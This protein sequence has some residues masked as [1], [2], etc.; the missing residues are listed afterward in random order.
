[1]YVYILIYGLAYVRLDGGKEMYSTNL[2]LMVFSLTGT[3]DI[4]SQGLFQAI[5][6]MQAHRSWT[7][8]TPG[9]VLNHVTCDSNR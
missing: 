6:S 8:P 9:V 2:G 7:E 1:M 3:G 4:P 5:P